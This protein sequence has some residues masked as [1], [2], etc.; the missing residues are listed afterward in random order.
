VK[1]TRPGEGTDGTRSRRR[2]AG[3]TTLRTI[4]VGGSWY[5]VGGDQRLPLESGDI[6]GHVGL[7]RFCPGICVVASLVDCASCIGSVLIREAEDRVTHLVHSDLSTRAGR[8]REYSDS[9][10]SRTAILRA[11]DHHEGH[12]RG[13][14]QLRRSHR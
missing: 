9:C 11:V 6:R 8:L 4:G 10:G 7:S 5:G 3:V 13:P 1:V 2:S 14:T 12:S